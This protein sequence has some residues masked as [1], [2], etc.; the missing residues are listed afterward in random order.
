M[1][2][3]EWLCVFVRLPVVVSGCVWLCFVLSDRVWLCVVMSSCVWLFVF[4][5]NCVILKG[6]EFVYDCGWLCVIF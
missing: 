1:C 6:Y 2:K 3:I 5:S 4:L